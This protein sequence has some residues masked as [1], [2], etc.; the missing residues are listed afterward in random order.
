MDL[1]DRVEE[2]RR[3]LET[4]EGRALLVTL[5]RD[6]RAGMPAGSEVEA[7]HRAEA[8]DGLPFP[9]VGTV[10][11]WVQHLRGAPIVCVQALEWPPPPGA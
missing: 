8:L 9:V 1:R 11:A 7:V 3:L 2:V 6:G 4:P 10:R 5:G